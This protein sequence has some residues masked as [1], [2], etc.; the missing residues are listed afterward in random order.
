MMYVVEIN[1]YKGNLYPLCIFHTIR[2]EY[3]H[4]LVG[5]YLNAGA[6]PVQIEVTIKVLVLQI[7]VRTVS[8]SAS[9]IECG[10]DT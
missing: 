10:Q 6:S 7:S 2:I 3:T 5:P 1:T 4:L 8:N 9:I